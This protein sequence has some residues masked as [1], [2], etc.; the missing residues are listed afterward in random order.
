MNCENVLKAAYPTTHLSEL[1]SGEPTEI[2]IITEKG[3][4]P[5]TDPVHQAFTYRIK[6]CDATGECK[7]TGES[8]PVIIVPEPGVDGML[9]VGLVCLVIIKRLRRE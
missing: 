5:D 2:Y 1:P 4:A 9:A 8:L 3:C 6:V 7:I